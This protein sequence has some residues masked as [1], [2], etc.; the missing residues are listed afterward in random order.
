MYPIRSTLRSNMLGKDISL[1]Y[2]V[3]SMIEIEHMHIVIS[4]SLTN[5]FYT[6]L[7]KNVLLYAHWDGKQ[8]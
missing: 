8:H 5:N 2:E 4:N 3:D 6:Q 7:L 1:Y